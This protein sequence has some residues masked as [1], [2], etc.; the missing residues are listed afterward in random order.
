MPNMILMLAGLV[1]SVG[2]LVAG[3]AIPGAQSGSKLYSVNN[4]VGTNGVQ[5][6]SD[7]PM[8]KITGTADGVAG[9]FALDAANLEVTTGRIEVQVVSM[10]TANSKRDGHMYSK[11]WLNASAH[12]LI[13]FD[14]KSL[15]DVNIVSKD[16]RN[17]ITAIAIGTFTCHGVTKPS[18]ADIAL[19]YIQASP[20]TQKRAG[21][22]LVMIEAR[23]VVALADHQ[24][25]GQAEIIGKSVG[26]SIAVRAQLFANSLDK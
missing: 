4:A 20:E 13:T 3:T 16:G 18:S 6:I 7:A 22:N 19:T 9:S 14:V 5:F 10:K 11:M 25:I 8:E 17:I 26:D 2:I 12:P 21:G 1:T 15:T 24:I 23:F